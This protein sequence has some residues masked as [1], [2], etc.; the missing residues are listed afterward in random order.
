MNSPRAN[1]SDTRRRLLEA[2]EALFI[3]HGY[4]GMLLRQITSEAK[5][6]LAAV[7]YHFGSKEALVQELL[8]S[9]L[10]RLNEE[11]LQLLSLLA[12]RQQIGRA[13]V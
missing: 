13:H 8:S 1:S 10:D 6:N 7:N 12:Q 4:E 3:R 9:R 5:V 2:A 11:R